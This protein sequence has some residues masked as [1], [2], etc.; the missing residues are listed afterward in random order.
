MPWTV[1]LFLSL[2]NTMLET[3]ESKKT[4]FSIMFFFVVFICCVLYA[5]MCVS[6]FFVLLYSHIHNIYII[7]F[8]RSLVSSLILYGKDSFAIIDCDGFISIIF[9]S[10]TI[11]SFFSQHLVFF[12]QFGFLGRL[13]TVVEIS[14]SHLTSGQNQIIK[15]FFPFFLPFYWETT[16]FIISSRND[17]FSC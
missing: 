11:D 7:L 2:L 6:S 17:D 14:S 16:F 8:H 5:F 1:C 13:I 10:K 3:K 9:V 15:I 4:V 12:Q